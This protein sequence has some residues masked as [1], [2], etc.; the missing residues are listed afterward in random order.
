MSLQ[1]WP[2]IGHRQGGRLKD[3]VAH[4]CD[5]FKIQ[6]GDLYPRDEKRE[7]INAE[8]DST[9]IQ[10]TRFYNAGTRSHHGIE[11]YVS[12]GSQPL[13]EMSRQLG[14]NLAGN[15]WELCEA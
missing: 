12:R 4:L 11:H 15:E 6:R 5:G 14:G 13:Y 9:S 8:S 3:V 10:Q 1:E 7:G 2:L